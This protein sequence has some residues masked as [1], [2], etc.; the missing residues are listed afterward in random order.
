MTDRG[1]SKP[2]VPDFDHATLIYLAAAPDENDPRFDFASDVLTY[3]DE[4]GIIDMAEDK[5]FVTTELG[6][7]VFTLMA[8]AAPSLVL[9]S[10]LHQVRADEM[11]D[12]GLMDD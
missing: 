3:M 2:S 9:E 11:R 7:W 6:K 4:V 12:L 10:A 5:S 1:M 8:P